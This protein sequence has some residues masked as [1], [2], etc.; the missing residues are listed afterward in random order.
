MI[1]GYVFVK[2]AEFF[3]FLHETNTS[4]VYNTIKNGYTGRKQTYN[5][6]AMHHHAIVIDIIDVVVDVLRFRH[7]NLL[8]G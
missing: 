8:Y 1:Y 6:L 7:V 2:R 3:F 4:S 5:Y